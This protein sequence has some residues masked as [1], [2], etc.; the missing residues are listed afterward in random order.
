[1]TTGR[2]I[3]EEEKFL[4]GEGDEGEYS[5]QDDEPA[6]II[7]NTP[8]A[9]LDFTAKGWTVELKGVI[10][11]DEGDLWKITKVT[12]K[13]GWKVDHFNTKTK[14]KQED[15]LQE[16]LEIGLNDSQDWFKPVYKDFMIKREWVKP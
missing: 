11:R 3:V 7:T 15:T 9:K 5:G 12:S 8:E 1:M 14:A 16:V 4:N 2:T 6:P 13:G 10:F